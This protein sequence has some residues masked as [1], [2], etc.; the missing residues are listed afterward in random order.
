[1][2]LILKAETDMLSLSAFCITVDLKGLN[3]V[4]NIHFRYM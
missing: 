4:Q 3:L 2:F 1:M